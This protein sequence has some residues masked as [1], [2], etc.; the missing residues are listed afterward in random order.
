MNYIQ[1]TAEALGL[2]KSTVYRSLHNSGKVS[3]KTEKRIRQYLSEHF[4]DKIKQHPPVGKGSGKPRFLTFVMPNKP[5]F[6]WDDVINGIKSA[7]SRYEKSNII[8]NYYFYSG[9]INDKEIISILGRLEK[10]LPDGMAIVPTRSKEIGRIISEISSR[11]PVVFMNDYCDGC[12]NVKRILTN[13]FEEGRKIGEIMCSQIS[14]GTVLILRSDGFES[15][16]IQ[17]RLRGFKDCCAKN[18]RQLKIK[19]AFYEAGEDRYVSNTILPS[20][21]ART[22]SEE[23]KTRADVKAVYIPNGVCCQLMMAVKKLG[24]TDIRV[25]SH[26]ADIKAKRLFR[27]G[28]RGG[29]VTSDGFN[30]GYLA[31]W[32]LCQSVLGEEKNE[33]PFLTWFDFEKFD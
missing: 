11:I 10:L 29:Y 28:M 22:I 31:A 17:E 14:D 33:A 12:E 9:D 13:G 7:E 24:K 16:V 2:S 19:E 20:I 23:L 6:F 25:Y 32:Y 3:T 27:N 30:Q 26:E 4:P 15:N 21:L 5:S 18:A 8:I 1:K